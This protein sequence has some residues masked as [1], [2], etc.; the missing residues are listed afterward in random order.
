MHLQQ[1]GKQAAFFFPFSLFNLGFMNLKDDVFLRRSSVVCCSPPSHIF[2][3]DLC[4]PLNR[5]TSARWTDTGGRID[6]DSKHKHNNVR[7]KFSTKHCIEAWNHRAKHSQFEAAHSSP[8]R[9]L[10]YGNLCSHCQWLYCQ[11]LSR[12]LEGLSWG[13]SLQ[14]ITGKKTHKV[15]S[16]MFWWFC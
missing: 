7:K 5:I 1:L 16:T 9:A 3:S 13:L 11:S 14:S 6:A 15:R 8:C 2:G 12:Q 10:V 4:H